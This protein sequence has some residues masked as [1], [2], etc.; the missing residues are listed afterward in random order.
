VKIDEVGFNQKCSLIYQYFEGSKAD[1]ARVFESIKESEKLLAAQKAQLFASLDKVQ[2]ETDTKFKRVMIIENQ[3]SC[4]KQEIDLMRLKK[5]KDD[6]KI[7]T[8]LASQ[9]DRL[10]KNER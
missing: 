7:R 2:K 6:A 5:G 4:V 9:V 10:A 3:V 1:N 8:Q